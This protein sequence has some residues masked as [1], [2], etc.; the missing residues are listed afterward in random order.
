[1]YSYLHG[2]V[3]SLCFKPIIHLA[4]R[5]CV[6]PITFLSNNARPTYSE[7]SWSS[8]LCYFWSSF[9]SVI[10]PYYRPLHSV[11]QISPLQIVWNACSLI[12]SYHSAGKLLHFLAY[13]SYEHAGLLFISSLFHRLEVGLRIV[14]FSKLSH[15][16]LL[17]L[18]VYHL[19]QSHVK[20]FLNW[21][22][23][24][25]IAQPLQRR[26]TD[27]ASGARFPAGP[28]DFSLHHR[29][30]TV[31]GAHPASYS[32]S[33]GGFLPGGKAAGV[34]KLT[35]HH[36]VPRSRIVKL[37]LH[38]PPCLYGIVF[39]FN[40]LSTGTVLPFQAYFPYF[41]KIK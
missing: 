10:P 18:L 21:F 1:M 14:R 23:A 12:S 2:L 36:L 30:Q 6:R 7:V 29:V 37:Y 41:E 31:P 5:T 33:T 9:V 25:R 26:A 19:I 4:Y 17:V 20:E 11:S 15:V 35:T 28:R 27:W 34:M 22:W 38:S 13:S 24:A 39:K 40:L 32:M 8:L 3:I 16:G